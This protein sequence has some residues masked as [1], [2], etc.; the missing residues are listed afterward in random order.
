MVPGA[1]ARDLSPPGVDVPM[2]RRS[3]YL[4][5]LVT[6]LSLAACGKDKPSSPPDIIEGPRCDTVAWESLLAGDETNLSAYGLFASSTDPTTNPN[7]T[8]MP[9]DL[10]TDLFTDYASKYRFVFIP[11]DSVAAYTE[12]E[13]FVFPVG[14]VIAKSFAM[15]ADTAVRGLANETLIET[16]LLIR[17][18]A[19]WVALPYTWLADGSD[20][21]LD[22]LGS[23]KPM[24]V[25]HRGTARSFSYGIPGRQ[26]C[27]AC[28]S[29]DGAL[30]PIGPKAR[31]LN[32]VF[33]YGTV[34]ENQLAHWQAAGRLRGVPADL[35]AIV[36]MPV[37]DDATDLTTLTGE[38]E[39]NRYAK[40]YLD[41]NCA[42]CHRP[43]GSYG[44]RT[45]YFEFWRGIDP[46][47]A[48]DDHGICRVVQPGNAAG[49]GLHTMM[50]IRRMPK[51]GT[52]L[53]HQEGL[54]LI[55]DW[56]TNMSYTCP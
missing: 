3:G 19:G 35:A 20:A 46:A 25:V 23:S 45:P 9:Y 5:L 17:R 14:T 50:R 2:T 44:P 12:H 29:L 11:C 31:N 18:A 13:A 1:N 28:H 22:T 40:A 27:L 49:S 39:R 7:D 41:I 8:G 55:A 42:H 37:F 56:I 54:A 4:L 26:Q 53:V 21:V 10:N 30:A 24:S 38:A 47:V 34:S 33:D 36:T 48:D 32:R 15:P 43:G 6:T 52:S 16:R 51:L